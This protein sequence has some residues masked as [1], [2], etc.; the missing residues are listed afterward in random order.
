MDP[1]LSKIRRE[2]YLSHKRQH[3]ESSASAEVEVIDVDNDVSPHP[4][5]ADHQNAS[6]ACRCCTF[7]NNG[8]RNSCE[9]CNHVNPDTALEN[10][11]DSVTFVPNPNA[12]KKAKTTSHP[13]YVNGNVLHDL[14]P[15]S[16]ENGGWIW[17]QNRSSQS[18][19]DVEGFV[20]K[21]KSHPEKTRDVVLELAR[22]HNVT[23]GKWLLY[24]KSEHAA[25]TWRKIRDAVYNGQLGEVAKISTD[26]DTRSDTFVICVYCK[27]FDDREDVLRVRKALWETS[28]IKARIF[29]KPDCF[30]Y[31]DINTG[32]PYKIRPTI[33]SCG[34]VDGVEMTLT[35]AK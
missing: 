10:D 12:S 20:A 8:E 27:D 6:W 11:D 14:H 21:F 18:Q 26:T 15:K 17:A 32:N 25:E 23:A 2:A 31:L 30:T 33:Y 5:K 19:A 35:D 34:V 9:M 7:I 28:Q 24:Q 22:Q 13:C 1:E 3:G 16:L 4:K 29:F